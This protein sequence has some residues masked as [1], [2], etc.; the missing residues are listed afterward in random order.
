MKSESLP[1]KNNYERIGFSNENSCY[2]TKRLKRKNLLFLPKKL[3]EK[4]PDACNAKKHYQSFLRKKK[5]KSVIQSEIITY[6]PKTFNT[7]DTKSVITENQKTSYD[8]SKTIR[9]AEKV[10]SYSSLY[11]DTRVK[12][13]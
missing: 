1:L 4:I 3:I 5:R 10:G 11:S 2:S 6:Q 7:V 12:F 13:F 9:Q 8:L